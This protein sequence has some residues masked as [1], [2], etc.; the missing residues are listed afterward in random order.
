MEEETIDTITIIPDERKVLTWEE[1][2]K[3]FEESKVRESYDASTESQL[4][5]TI[6][7]MYYNHPVKYLLTHCIISKAQILL[8]LD[9]HASEH[10]IKDDTYRNSIDTLVENPK[11]QIFLTIND[12]RPCTKLHVSEREY[13]FKKYGDMTRN[14]SI[15]RYKGESLAVDC[16][17]FKNASSVTFYRCSRIKNLPELA[18]VKS[19][20]FSECDNTTIVPPLSCLELLSFN[21]CSHLKQ[22]RCISTLKKLVILDCPTA[23]IQQ[24]M[25]NMDDITL[26]NCLPYVV[27][28]SDMV[29]RNIIELDITWCK[30]ASIAEISNV[31]DVRISHCEFLEKIDMVNNVQMLTIESCDELESF[32]ISNVKSFSISSCQ[33]LKQIGHIKELDT[34]QVLNCNNL[35][36]IE[37][38]SNTK[39]VELKTCRDLKAIKTIKNIDNFMSHACYVLRFIEHIENVPSYEFGT[40]TLNTGLYKLFDDAHNLCK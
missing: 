24:Q 4:I 16:N 29:F 40:R 10:Y 3:Y 9:M 37:S 36:T 2:Q 7:V 22:I 26:H 32:S 21:M 30:L 31:R 14:T 25:E 12:T 33:Q 39:D 8:D 23:S 1:T 28:S 35:E 27:E 15:G 17:L 6:D 34:F 19:L 20:R 18:K 11:Q 13:A 5:F 38:I